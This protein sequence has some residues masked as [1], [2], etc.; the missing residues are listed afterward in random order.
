MVSSQMLCIN[1]AVLHSTHF[2]VLLRSGNLNGYEVR[3]EVNVGKP[4]PRESLI[5]QPAREYNVGAVL[6]SDHWHFFLLKKYVFL[7]LLFYLLIVYYVYS[8]LCG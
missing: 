4:N 5:H 2:Q 3:V 6:Q 1:P 7:L 8:V